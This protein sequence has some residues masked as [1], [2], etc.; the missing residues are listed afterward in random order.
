MPVRV[1]PRIVTAETLA[2]LPDEERHRVLREIFATPGEWEKLTRTW[3][4]VGR[5]EQ[6]LPPGEWTNWLYLAGRGAGK[7][8]TGAETVRLWVKQGYTRIGLI[9]PTAGDARDVM[10]EGESGI[11]AV[12]YDEDIDEFGRKMGKPL[13]ESSKRR[14]TWHNGA[15][16]TLFSAD[17]PERLR[18]P[19]HEK[20]WADE[21]ASWRRPIAWDL[22]MFGLRL[23]DNPQA[24]ISTTPK[25]RKLLLDIVK[26]KGTVITKGT[27]ASNKA[28]LAPTFLKTVV[29]KYAGTR[30]GR[31]ELDGQLIT[32][33]QGALWRRAALDECRIPQIPQH[34]EFFFVRIVVAV[35]PAIT[36][37][38]NTSNETGIIVAGLGSDG[39]VYILSDL[40]EVLSPNDWA[41]RAA[42]AFRLWQGDMIVAEGNQG[43]E[44]VRQTI[45]SVDAR[46]PVKLVHASRGKVARAEPIAALYE[47]KRVVHVGDFREL[48]DQMCTWENLSGQKSP[49]RID[50]LVWAVHALTEGGAEGGQ[51]EAEGAF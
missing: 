43:G 41:S 17:E 37:D 7:T 12:C 23:G 31:Q 21:L 2:R 8:R 50:A 28:N 1:A 40:S 4:F 35:D 22:A 39:K 19:Q 44:M 14:V 38:P 26:D 15:M 46:L 47:Q 34:T 30:L 20:I 51:A 27:T 6:Q 11:L 18:G 3:S 9:A 49:D 42:G 32:E 25:P 29:G 36:H 48:E 24:F 33:A 45:Q 13:Y 16:C 10:V 5:A